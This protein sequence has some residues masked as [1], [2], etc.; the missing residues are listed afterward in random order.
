MKHII[1]CVLA[2]LNFV[3]SVRTGPDQGESVARRS[4]IFPPS[5]SFLQ[6]LVKQ[7]WVDVEKRIVASHPLHFVK[8][9]I[10]ADVEAAER[11]WRKTHPKV[12]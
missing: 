2:I 8:P 9:D 11:T 12:T 1:L 4:T 7:K 3:S 10:Q 6:L 5:I